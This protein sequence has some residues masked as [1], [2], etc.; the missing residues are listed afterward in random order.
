MISDEIAPIVVFPDDVY[1]DFNS[2]DE[3][4]QWY[5]LQQVCIH[6]EHKEDSLSAVIQYY[7]PISSV[8]SFLDIQLKYY[9][10]RN[11]HGNSSNCIA[12]Q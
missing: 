6:N 7:E 4:Q 3:Y 10:I 11:S 5:R 2:I 8:L 12:L 9:L 1:S